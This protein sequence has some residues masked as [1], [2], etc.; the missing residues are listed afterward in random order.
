MKKE[1][2]IKTGR[3]KPFSS[4]LLL[5]LLIFFAG[6]S[7]YG[8]AQQI[9]PTVICSAGGSFVTSSQSI[10]FSLGEIAVETYQTGNNLLSEGFFQGS[11]NETGIK[12]GMATNGQIVIYPNP[13]HGRITVNCKNDPVKMT[14]L[15]LRGRTL[16]QAQNP[17]KITTLNIENLQSGLYI[18]RVTFKNN[19]PVTNRIIKN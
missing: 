9:T 19:I 5:I 11:K 4:L 2:N 6:L 1:S 14:I 7:N 13:S 15:D 8:I 3:E 17:G 18:I 10:Q 16:S 12:E